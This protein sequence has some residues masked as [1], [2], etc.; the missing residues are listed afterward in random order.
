[1]NVDELKA[2][3]L[4]KWV[5]IA[6]E[7]RPSKNP[8]GTL[9]PF[10]LTRSF[11]YL[12]EDRFE[13][14]VMNYADAFAKVPIAK[15]DIGGHRSWGGEHRMRPGAQK[16]DLGARQRY[17]VPPLLQGFAEFLKNVCTH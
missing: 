12:P 10:F 2:A 5:S 7:V 15:I 16:V 14:T 3:L 17:P 1:M 4:G 9:K 8:D 13:L 11:A 6:P